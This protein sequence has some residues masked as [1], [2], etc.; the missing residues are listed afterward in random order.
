MEMISCELMTEM[1]RW[2]SILGAHPRR[3]RNFWL[4]VSCFCAA[5]I[6][7][8]LSYDN[9]TSTSTSNTSAQSPPFG[10]KASQRTT[11][12]VVASQRGDDIAWLDAFPQWSKSIY[13]TDDPA[14]A[15]AVPANKGREGMVYLTYII[16]NYDKLPTSVIFSHSKRYQWHNDDP[17]YDGQAVLRRLNMSYVESVGYASLRCC[18]TLGCPVEIRPLREAE[19]GYPDSDPDSPKARAG[20]FFKAAFEQMFP[21]QRVPEEVGAPCCAQF[22]VTA[23][24]IR[25]RPRADYERYRDWLLNTSLSDY[26]SGRIMEYSWHIIFGKQ[27]VHC[28]NAGHCYCK[29]FGLCKLKCEEEGKCHAAYT[30]PKYSTLP[31]GWPDMDWNNQWRNVT[32]LVSQFEREN[33]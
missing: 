2:V 12:I 26:L 27:A 10:P 32:A 14:A 17:V 11:Q 1:Q 29:L 9:W 13:V 24:T 5:S 20:S 18:W 6:F 31:T 33:T 15:L 21:G 30:L 28:P 3:L 19:A 16:E 7:T 4:L 8:K 22:A 25:Q 23:D